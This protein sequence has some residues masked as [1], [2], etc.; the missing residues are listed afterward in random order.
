MQNNW[1][2]VILKNKKIAEKHLEILEEETRREK[3]FK[4][5]G[6]FRKLGKYQNISGCYP[7]Q[8]EKDEVG[9]ILQDLLGNSNPNNIMKKIHKKQLPVFKTATIYNKKSKKKYTNSEVRISQKATF[10][11]N[12]AVYKK[13]T[14]MLFPKIKKNFIDSMGNLTGG[15][16]T[17][18]KPC[19]HL[20]AIYYPAGG[21]FK[22]HRDDIST[23]HMQKAISEGYVIYTL[24]LCLSKD[25]SKINSGTTTIWTP[26]PY[27]HRSHYTEYS[28]YQRHV[29]PT[30]SKQGM[31]IMFP[32]NIL[33]S[34]NKCF[35]PTLK[36]KMDFYVKFK[37]VNYNT[38]SYIPNDCST[39]LCCNRQSKL[40]IS[41]W[42]TF[43]CKKSPFPNDLVLYISK[44]LGDLRKCY[45]IDKVESIMYLQNKHLPRCKRLCKCGCNFCSHYNHN[46][47]TCEYCEQEREYEAYLDDNDNDDNDDK[48]CN[49]H[50]Y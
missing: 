8:L 4:I 7:I 22:P 39:C 1:N 49:G 36:L 44:Y 46:L 37:Y 16:N 47:C 41:V 18:F 26:Y 2:I 9:N 10:H 29:W 5:L 45:C 25:Y 6:R 31:G 20:D 14:N 3:Y 30:G 27:S 34:G 28:N 40:K 32:S 17:L 33:H 43:Y 35:K 19:D 11:N 50:D 21:I 13:I 23:A 12:T 42:K 24:I 38:V 15:K 48:Y